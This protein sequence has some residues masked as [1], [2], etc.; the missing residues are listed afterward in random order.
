MARYYI[1]LISSL[2]M[3]HFGAK[4]PFSFERFLGICQG[5]ISDE[6]IKA[7]KDSVQVEGV[8]GYGGPGAATLR[9]WYTFDVALRN[10]LA[11]IRASRKHLDP[12]KYLRH[13]AYVEPDI[14]HSALNVHR[15]PSILDAE[16]ALDQE[17]WHML[18]ELSYG[19]YFD[20]DYLFIYAQ[21]LLILER[22]EAIRTADKS[23]LLEEVLVK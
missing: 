20:M 17:R 1:Y 12:A 22:W 13:Y 14:S 23:R 19:H 10:E 21:K 16:K 6:E 8:T 18:E 7:L 3:L 5:L 11:K 9:K 2:P 15:N 4:P